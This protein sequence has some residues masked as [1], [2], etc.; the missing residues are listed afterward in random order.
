MRRLVVGAFLAFALT[1][2]G[3]ARNFTEGW[4]GRTEPYGGV[5]IALDG[6]DTPG[7]RIGAAFFPTD[8]PLSAVGDTLTLPI[9]LSVAVARKIKAYYNPPVSPEPPAPPTPSDNTPPTSHLTP[10]RIHGGII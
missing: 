9:T 1:G 5:R 4:Q 7:D 3:T 10:E 2:C 8:V 6:P